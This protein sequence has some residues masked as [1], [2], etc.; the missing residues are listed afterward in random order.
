M[1]PRSIAF[2][3][4]AA[5][6]KLPGRAD[7]LVT[8]VST[9]SRKVQAGDLFIALKGEKFDA[10]DFLPE[11]IAKS[12]AAVLARVGSESQLKGCSAILVE[13]T[14]AALGSLA[15]AY[16]SDFEL[17]VIAVAGSNGKTTTKELI[18][19]ALSRKL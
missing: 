5:G 18:N 7:A 9:D 14:R 12:P 13:D 1:D 6:G 4:R 8:R 11:V 19:S 16:R 15:A 2:I 17:P 3:A 10:H